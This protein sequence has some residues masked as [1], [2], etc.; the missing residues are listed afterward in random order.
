MGAFR[1]GSL[2][3]ASLSTPVLN[4]SPCF[5]FAKSGQDLYAFLPNIEVNLLLTARQISRKCGGEDG[6]KSS[7]W[8]HKDT[9]AKL[10]CGLG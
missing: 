9:V 2:P 7:S 6:V 10:H 4:L 1:T 5:F 8:L 3:G